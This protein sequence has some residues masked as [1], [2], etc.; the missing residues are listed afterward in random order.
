MAF[1]KSSKL[2]EVMEDSAASVILE[3]YIPNITQD[4]RAKTFKNMTLMQ[5]QKMSM[6]VVTPETLECID[7]ELK[8]LG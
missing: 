8:A 3:K 7:T 6:G 5:L 1:S 2:K 4:R